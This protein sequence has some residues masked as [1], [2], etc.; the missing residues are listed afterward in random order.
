MGALGATHQGRIAR[1]LARVLRIPP[2]TVSLLPR[3][4]NYQGEGGGTGAQQRSAHGLAGAGD[5]RIPVLR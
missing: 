2:L 1:P 4:H 5:L 3:I